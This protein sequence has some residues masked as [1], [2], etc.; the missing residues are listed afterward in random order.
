MI[1]VKVQLLYFDDC[2]NWRYAANLLDR[3]AAETA[4]V[5]VEHRLVETQEEAERLAFRG[6]PSIHVDG[7]DLFAGEGDPVGIS[8]R[9]YQTPDGAAGSPTLGQLRAAIESANSGR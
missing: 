4:G 6:S 1:V 7:R 2:P 3:L 8:C 5:E 9:L